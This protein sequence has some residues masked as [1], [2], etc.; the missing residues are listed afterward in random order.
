MNTK[1][2]FQKQEKEKFRQTNM[3][4]LAVKQQHVDSTNARICMA[5]QD[6]LSRDTG[7]IIKKAQVRDTY[8]KVNKLGVIY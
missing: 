7:L 6:L 5:D 2:D 8:E 1:V 3:A 4:R